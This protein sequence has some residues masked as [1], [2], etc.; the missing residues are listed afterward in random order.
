[1]G[2][3]HIKRLAAPKTWQI[4]T[5]G[6]KFITKPAPGPHSL[7]T[8]MPLSTLLKEVLNYANTTREVKKIL[9]TNEI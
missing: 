7:D 1:M 5:K 6:L 9:N 3:D 8:G 2:R 4:R